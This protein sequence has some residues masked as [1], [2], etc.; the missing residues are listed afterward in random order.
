MIE[1]QTAVREAGACGAR[2]LLG[3]RDYEVRNVVVSWRVLLEVRVRF[4]LS[5]IRNRVELSGNSAVLYVYDSVAC[6][7]YVVFACCHPFI[8]GEQFILPLSTIPRLFL[9]GVFTI[10][11]GSSTGEGKTSGH[12]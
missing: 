8:C 4:L 1:I 7:G 9:L 3:D 2:V 6:V 11:D 5:M 10:D 12:G